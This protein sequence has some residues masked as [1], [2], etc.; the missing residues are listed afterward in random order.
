MLFPEE[1]DIFC[2]NTIFFRC[3]DY[4]RAFFLYV[5]YF[6]YFCLNFISVEK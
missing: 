2:K 6:S 5:D 3:W 1:C 4:F